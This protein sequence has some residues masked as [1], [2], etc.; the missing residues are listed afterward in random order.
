[1]ELLNVPS[2]WGKGNFVLDMPDSTS[3]RPAG[4]QYSL[5]VDFYRYK[6]NIVAKKS[7]P[8]FFGGLTWLHG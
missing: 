6:S 1:M 5:I 3:T 8:T 4:N 2:A 7:Y